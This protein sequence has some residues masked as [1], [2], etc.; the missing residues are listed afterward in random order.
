MNIK[1]RQNT[2]TQHN[3]GVEAHVLGFKGLYHFFECGRGSQENKKP[4]KQHRF[5]NAR[6]ARTDLIA[7][8]KTGWKTSFSKQQYNLAATLLPFRSAITCSR[9]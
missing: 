1:G 2:H 5:N 4:Y 8:D 7:T 3:K 6:R 9:W